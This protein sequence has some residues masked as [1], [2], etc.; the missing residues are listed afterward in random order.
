MDHPNFW[1][2]CLATQ[3]GPGHSMVKISEHELMQA[4]KFGEES[5]DGISL[6]DLSIA[7]QGS[8]DQ[9][10]LN[11]LEAIVPELKARYGFDVMEAFMRLRWI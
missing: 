4:L 3:E 7:V 1:S 2:F 11:V 10:I 8:S 6:A 5:I 9:D